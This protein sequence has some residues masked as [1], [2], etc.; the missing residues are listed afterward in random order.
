MKLISLFLLFITI[1][2]SQVSFD[3]YFEDKTLR[4]DYYHTGNK[5]TDSYSFDEMIEEPFWGSSK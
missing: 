2:H 1:T 4:F 5:D 3:E